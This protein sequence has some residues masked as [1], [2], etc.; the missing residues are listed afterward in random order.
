[1]ALSAAKRYIILSS[2]SAP[3][4]DIG[5]PGQIG[6]G[7]GIAPFLPS[8]MSPM[9]GTRKRGHDNYGNYQFSDGSI[10][11]YRPAFYYKWGSGSN[12]LAI[13][14]LDIKKLAAFGSV[15]EANA[16]G[17]ALH[18]A[19]INGGLV[20]PGIFID[21]YK[22][23][24]NSGVASSIKL[25]N[26][27]SSHVD[28][29]PFS[30]LTGAPPNFYYGAITA[31]RTR[32]TGWH[33][34]SI[35]EHNTSA[36]ISY[37]HGQLANSSTCAW[38]D[39]AG[40]TNFPKGCNNN[41]LGDIDD[42]TL[43]FINDN[44][45]NSAK[46]GSANNLAKTTD[47]GQNCGIADVNGGV[48]GIMLGMTSNGANFYLLNESV[49][50]NIITSGNT[51]ATDAWGAS[52]IAAMYTSIGAA[53]GALTASSTSKLMGNAGKVFDESV[54]GNGYAATCAGIPLLDGGTNKFGNDGLWDYRPNELCPLVGGAWTNG[55]TAGV[56]AL[57]LPHAR[58]STSLHVGLRAAL[59]L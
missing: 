13:N 27:L 38:F 46:T 12:G 43:T 50:I 1:M 8:D 32:G 9:S 26:P 55:A 31:A 23:S 57:Y 4:N 54:A 37:A 2:S 25:G 10:V 7:V 16:A 40:I 3:V 18:R 59:F 35:F 34:Q 58:G 20:R 14:Q 5:I 41:A 47:N 21:K 15:A 22:C 24:N 36:M 51:L 53:Y 17:Y 39:P 48:W 29:N 19:F 30:G 11:V 6:F 49:D 52:G 28:H 33:C 42:N 56:W 45:L 44:Y